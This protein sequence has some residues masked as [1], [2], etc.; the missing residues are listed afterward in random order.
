MLLL[1]QS[2]LIRLFQCIGKIQKGCESLEKP[3]KADLA[4][5]VIVRCVK[6]LETEGI[7]LLRTQH[8]NT[9][10]D[11]SKVNVFF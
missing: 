7:D 2:D 9:V 6:I 8:N 4:K 10:H 1:L 5:F 11:W 3:V